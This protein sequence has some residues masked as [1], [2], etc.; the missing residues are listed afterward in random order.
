MIMKKQLLVLLALLLCFSVV[1]CGSDNNSSLSNL[2]PN[3]SESLEGVTVGKGF[4]DINISVDAGSP[5][6]AQGKLALYLDVIK[7]TYEGLE[8]QNVTADIIVAFRGMAVTLITTSTSDEV[9]GLIAEL[10]S[11]GVKFEACNVATSLF[12]V[13]NSTILQEVKVV[14]NTFISA[15]GYQA[16]GY[17]PILIQ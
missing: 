17:S 2:G 15:I 11:L 3:D 8:D 4:F 9:K 13:D 5:E 1:G 14:G 12:E 6:A 7:Q 16:K 10:D